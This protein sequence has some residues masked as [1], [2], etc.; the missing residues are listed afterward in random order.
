VSD[1][2]PARDLRRPNGATRRFDVAEPATV[3]LVRHGVTE[4]TLAGT[5]A[6]SSVAGPSLHAA[7]RV[8]AAQAAD[9]VHRIGRDAWA[10]LPRASVVVASP[11]TRTQETAAAVGRRLGV[12]VGTDARFAELDFG[13]YDGLTF[14]EVEER[15]PG[16]LE[17]FYTGD[18][19]TAAPGGESMSELGERVGAGL[20][21]LVPAGVGRTTVV[22]S[23]AMA[24]RAAVGLAFGS[25]PAQWTRTRITPASVTILRLWEDGE[26]EATAVGCPP[27]L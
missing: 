17:R 8:Q 23:H 16:W 12:V 15:D 13:D 14:P 25:P 24:I 5:F 6:G 11:T 19:H 22:V 20:R 7:G 4:H 9:L 10:D 2:R 3:V 1:A 27:D 18:G 21:S 26:V